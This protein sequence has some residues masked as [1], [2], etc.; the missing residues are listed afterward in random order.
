MNSAR[1]RRVPV[2]INMLEFPRS[3]RGRYAPIRCRRDD[4]G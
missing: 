1:N 4:S 2:A 3:S